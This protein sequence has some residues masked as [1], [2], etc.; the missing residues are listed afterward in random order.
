MTPF[1]KFLLGLSAVLLMGWIYHG[2]VGNGE[3]LVDRLEAQS[4]QVVTKSNVPG[5]DVRFSRDPLSRLAIM[6]GNADP[7]QREGQGELKGLNDLVGEVPGVSGVRWA[8]EAP[9]STVPLLAE[10]LL[11]L[12]LAYLIGF[13]LAWLIFRRRNRESYY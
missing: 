9:R 5:V 10:T 6:S 8:D 12:L 7:F 2:P 13:G 4:E 3:A 1:V 11:Q